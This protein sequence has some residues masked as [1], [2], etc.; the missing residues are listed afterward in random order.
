MPPHLCVAREAV[1]DAPCLVGVIEALGQHHELGQQL[2]VQV[3]GRVDAG[4]QEAKAPAI[5][6]AIMQVVIEVN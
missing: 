3:H 6:A 4:V 2:I 5:A 1:E